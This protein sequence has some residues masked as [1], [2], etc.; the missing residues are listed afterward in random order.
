MIREYQIFKSQ[1]KG[2]DLR[3]LMELLIKWMFRIERFEIYAKDLV[4][5]SS[6]RESIGFAKCDLLGKG[7]VIRKGKADDLKRL[8]SFPPPLPWQFQ[9]HKYDRVHDF[10]LAI[11][12]EIIQHVVWIY[13]RNDPNR[14]IEL[15][16]QEAEIKAAFTAPRFR[17]KGLYRQAQ[18]EITKYLAGK[19]F[20]RAYQSISHSNI[21]S[22]SAASKAGFR[23][24]GEVNLIRILGMQV[25]KK[26][27]TQAQTTEQ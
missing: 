21:P 16:P 14:F 12:G 22:K 7:T 18:L 17:G 23:L 4:K 26:F 2:R 8:E 9:C 13:Y 25:S 11:D 27:V 20:H 19:G 24:Q 1:I 5:T 15:G 10:F 6:R 3:G